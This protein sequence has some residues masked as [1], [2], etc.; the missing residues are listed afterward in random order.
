[1]ITSL[2]KVDILRAGLSSLGGVIGTIFAAYIFEKIED[3]QNEIIKYTILSL[4]LV[5]SIPK[6][7][8]FLVG[9]CYGIPYDG[10]FSVTYPLGLNQPVFPIQFVE[11]IMFFLLWMGINHF[12]N[13][14]HI[15]WITIEICTFTK[16]LLDF[17]RYDHVEKVITTTQILC[18]II[19]ILPLLIKGGRMIYDNRRIKTRAH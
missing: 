14:K 19:F 1:M 3:H 16:F 9:C 6:I 13:K 10:F 8:C 15:T 11:V 7:G 4:P 12:K 5:Y 17:L 2:G 18:I